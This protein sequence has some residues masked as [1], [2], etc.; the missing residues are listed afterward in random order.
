MLE[1]AYFW[2]IFCYKALE[3]SVPE[4]GLAYIYILFISKMLATA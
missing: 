1:Y 2:N 4:V 3:N